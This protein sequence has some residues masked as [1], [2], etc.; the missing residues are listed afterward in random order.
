[1]WPVRITAERYGSSRPAR[2]WRTWNCCVATIGS[3]RRFHTPA[4][5]AAYASL[6]PTPWK[7]GTSINAIPAG[8]EKLLRSLRS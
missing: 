2:P 3:I 1:M 8:G 7:S 4:H 5:L 6:G